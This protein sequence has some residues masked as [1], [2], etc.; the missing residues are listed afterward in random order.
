VSFSVYRQNQPMVTMSHSELLEAS[1]QVEDIHMVTLLKNPNQRGPVLIGLD[2]IPSIAKKQEASDEEFS[3]EELY[4]RAVSYKDFRRMLK[5]GVWNL[6][7]LPPSTYR[8]EAEFVIDQPFDIVLY[9]KADTAGHV[10]RDIV[11]LL[12]DWPDGEPPPL[13][14]EITERIITQLQGQPP[15]RLEFRIRDVQSIADEADLALP[16]DQHWKISD[17]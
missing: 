6:E 8:I 12:Q 1:D 16:Q 5:H 14:V 13:A 15:P 9:V 17:D 4:D 10:P 2:G 3:Y 11:Q 7:E